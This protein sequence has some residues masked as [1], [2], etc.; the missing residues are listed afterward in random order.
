MTETPEQAQQRRRYVIHGW[1][2]VNRLLALIGA[3][4]MFIA[5]IVADGESVAGTPMW[6]WAFWGVCA[7]M[8]AGVL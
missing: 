8:L 7:W 4:L 3:I 2:T 1:W 5:G 6:A